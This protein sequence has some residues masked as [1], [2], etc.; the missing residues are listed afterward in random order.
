MSD[1]LTEIVGLL[2]P[3]A[4]HAKQVVAAGRWAVRRSNDERPFYCAVLD[5]ACLLSPAGQAPV[6][7]AAGDF[8]LVPAARDFTASSLEPPPPGSAA[9]PSDPPLEVGPGL[10]RL[11]S[12]DGPPETRMLVGHCAFASLDARLLVSL[13]PRVV[14]V[15]GDPRLT[16]LVELVDGET[17]ASR[18]GRDAVLARLLEVLLIEAF[19]SGG[20]GSATGSVGTAGPGLLRGLA[21]ERVAPALRRMHAEPSRSWTVAEL[22]REAALS[23]SSFF[24]RFRREVGTAPMDYLLTW[25]M[26]L[27][28]DM[29]RR[30]D[31]GVGEV[32][33]WVGYASASTFSAAFARH[34]GTPPGL[35]AKGRGA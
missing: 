9:P 27:A 14:H 28:R 25:R 16:A 3:S 32:A 8:A 11:G 35:Y 17:R 13:L 31:A 21:D 22:A 26:A 7:L 1:P 20:T 15:R 30:R 2:K 18:P 6:R 33:G 4:P 10:F 5:G 19:R 24:E 12:G 34:T 29:L 23:R